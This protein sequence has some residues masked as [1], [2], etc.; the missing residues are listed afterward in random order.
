[1]G[2][3]W[4][5]LRCIYSPDPMTYLSMANALG[6]P[7]DVYDQLVNEHHHDIQFAELASPIDWGSIQWSALRLSGTALRRVTIPTSYQSVVEQARNRTARNG[8][9]DPRDE[10]SADWGNG[11]SWIRP[12]IVLG[13]D[14]SRAD[15]PNALVLGFERFGILLGALDRGD[16]L[17]P[18]CHAIWFGCTPS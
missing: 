9:L 14:P 10:L 1:M 18:E 6:W 4:D 17:E 16:L 3:T 7:L 13:S 12:P 8:I 5:S 15:P 11:G 2:L